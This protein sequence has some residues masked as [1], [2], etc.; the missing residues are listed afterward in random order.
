MKCRRRVWDVED[1]AERILVRRA[2][3]Q[4]TTWKTEK[5]IR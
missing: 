2:F 3:F 4:N 1:N 5:E